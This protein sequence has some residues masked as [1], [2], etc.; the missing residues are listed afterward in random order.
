MDT[1]FDLIAI[2][3]GSGG[4]AVAEKA[5]AFGARAAVIER[6]KLGGTCVNVGCV[7]KKVMWYAANLAADVRHAPEMG[8][9]ARLEGVDWAALVAGREGFIGGILDFWNG[10]VEGEGITHIH[11]DAHFVDA[12]TVVV[13]GTQYTADHIVIATGGRP[14]VPPVPGAEL[15]ITS[16]GFFALRE[17]PKRVCVVGGGYIGVEL[18]G[19]MRALGSAVTVVALESRVL[20]TFD[21]MVSETVAANMTQDGIDMHLPF[22]V[23]ALERRDDGI[24]V[25]GKEHQALTGFDTVLWAVGRRPNTEGLGL[26][27]A[28]VDVLPNGVI[29]TDAFQ[30][31]SVAGVYALGDIT[32]RA[33]L[34]PVAIA[35][36]RRLGERLFGDR[37][38]SRLD[39]ENIPTVVFAHPPA[40]AV[41][42]TEQDAR[43]SGEKITIYQTKFQ[44][45]RYALNHQGPQTAMKLVCVGADERVVGIHM[46]GDG[47][48][49]MLQG[50]AVAVKM[51]ATK[52]QFDA[53]VA[54]HPVSAEELVTLKEPH[55]ET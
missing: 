40:G 51:G 36:G 24:A 31:T 1:H 7:P 50:F 46:V 44:P 3:G 29:P 42:L 19:V 5:A 15:G 13:D 16:D 22:A 45:M 39:Y 11:G 30:N 49:E 47:V 8:I 38:N 43:A 33:P 54:I 18:A 9:N 53:T 27:A 6:H 35:A 25:I 32:G 34:T 52:A 17:Q 14:I 21:P 2:G 23:A 28:G 26:D 41:G 12:H 55:P 10:Y 37:P 48:D 4:L 20:E